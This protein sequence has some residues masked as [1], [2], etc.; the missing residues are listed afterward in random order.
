MVSAR[1]LVLCL[2]LLSVALSV[3]LHANAQSLGAV[4]PAKASPPATPDGWVV[5]PVDDYRALRARAYP[6]DPAPAPPPIDVAIARLDYDV[7]VRADA[8]AGTA[9][10][11]VDV[12]ADSWVRIGVPDDLLIGD[13]RVD[14][15]PVAIVEQ[16]MR[17]VLLSRRGR[18]VLTLQ[19]VLPLTRTASGDAVVLPPAGAAATQVAL[20]M[21]R[22]DV[23]VTVASGWIASRTPTTATTRW[24]AHGRGDQ[25][26]T[27]SWRRRVEARR[28]AEPLRW[29]GEV[30]QLV[31]LGEDATQVTAAV[32]VD[33]VSGAAREVALALPT[34]L[35]VTR[36]TGPAV[37][38]WER[39]GPEELR[40][41]FLDPIAGSTAFSLSAEQGGPATG[42]I[43]IPVIRL[44]E[45]DRES[46]GVAVE[47]LG[48][49]EI[50]ARQPQ[51]L[52]PADPLDLGA[53][54]SGRAS[55]SMVAYR[56]S[57]G[58]GRVPRGLTVSV[59]RYA[60]QAALVANVDEARYQVLAAEDGKT[61]VRARYAVRNNHRGL[62]SVMLPQ[63]ATLWSASV[64][65]E[66]VRP[67]RTD[68]G[69][70][71]VPLVRARTRGDLPLFVVELAYLAPVPALSGK[72]V[73]HLP[74]PAIDLP[75]SR[76]G[77]VLHHSPRFRVSAVPGSFR[78]EPFAPPVSAVLREPV[79]PPPPAAPAADDPARQHVDV[80]KLAAKRPGTAPGILPLEIAFP[81]FGP[82]VYL[83]TELTPETQ[84][85]TLAI[86]YERH[87]GN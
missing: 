71:L 46:G 62:L 39:P 75:I 13:A 77:V 8:V 20:S 14:G 50:T 61:L 35:Q 79:A 40:V 60:T 85:A 72:G 73:A 87:R 55:P 42:E 84:S 3:A 28:A 21:P 45:A 49:G 5:I 86:E 11:T 31:A 57:P 70:L 34:A 81:E 17:H 29:R 83:A 7:E 38:D 9:S 74:L 19:V 47:V 1:S 68:R 44:A 78:M 6:V 63:G 10:L 48:A 43:A 37:A 80:P 41:R 22:T 25:P 82:A 76:T 4:A 32:R 12:L 65:G 15:R 53:V 54:V 56:F 67:G 59:V 69:A 16:P 51:A 2:L 30:T 52:E 23:D 27:I 18:S 64:A 26:I 36:V 33:V 58:S 66:V 24:L